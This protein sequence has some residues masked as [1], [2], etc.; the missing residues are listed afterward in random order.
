MPRIRNLVVAAFMLF[1]VGPA[2]AAD[3]P[4]SED[5]IRELMRLT[6]L[7]KSLDAVAQNIK[8]STEVSMRH[9]FGGQALS[10]KQEKVLTEMSA[11]LDAML[12]EELGADALEPMYLEI[13][14]KALTQQE[15]DGM[16]AFYK[17]DAGRAV[18]AKMPTVAKQ[19]MEVTLRRMQTLTPRVQQLQRET[20]ERMKEPQ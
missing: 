20:L 14:R 4:P 11:Q 2:S 7:R 16:I 10:E 12:K 3:A 15:V 18:V 1:S 17:T 19:T 13:Y 6:D 8:S 5:S 9:A